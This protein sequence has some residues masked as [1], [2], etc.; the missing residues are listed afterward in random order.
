MSVTH[1]TNLNMEDPPMN[2]HVLGGGKYV[3]KEAFKDWR[4]TVFTRH[5]QAMNAQEQ[6]HAAGV[7]T[8]QD[9]AQLREERVSEL[10][11][12]NIQLEERILDLQEEIAA[13][14]AQGHSGELGSRLR[15]VLDEFEGAG[16]KRRRGIY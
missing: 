9:T 10:Q 16:A 8:M 1:H 6:G 15:Q 5:D 4:D 14:K 3:P 2:K 12:Q 13:L 7:Q 11:A